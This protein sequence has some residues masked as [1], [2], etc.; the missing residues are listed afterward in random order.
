[1]LRRD[2]EE[3]IEVAATRGEAIFRR[4]GL[5]WGSM[6]VPDRDMVEDTI[7]E[8]WGHLEDDPEISYV[9]TGRITL[10]RRPHDPEWI[11]IHFDLASYRPR[12]TD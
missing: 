12:S 3:A 9:S 5:E 4:L 1:M 7:R 6:G 11:E 10:R 2:K 8:L